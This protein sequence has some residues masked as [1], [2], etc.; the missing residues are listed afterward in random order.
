MLSETQAIVRLH[1]IEFGQEP[2][3]SRGRAEAEARLCRSE[4]SQNL[5][6]KYEA[7]KQRYGARAVVEVEDGTCSGCHLSLPKSLV[8]GLNRGGWVL[9][10]HCARIL[11]DPDKVFDF[12]H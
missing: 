1:E 2:P 6:R 8:D 9:C 3:S 5:L 4:I 7:L 12:Q 11:F 10:D